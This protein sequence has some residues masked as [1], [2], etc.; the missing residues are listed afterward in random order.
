PVFSSH[1][2]A[3]RKAVLIVVPDMKEVMQMEVLYN[4]QSTDSAAL[5][6]GFWFT[7]NDVEA[8]D[9]EG[10]GFDGAIDL[11]MSPSAGVSEAVVEARPSKEKGAQLFKAAACAGCHS[12][13]RETDG[14]Y[15]PPFKDVFMSE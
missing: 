10:A 9:L 11:S 13:G 12:T 2:S 5:E 1:I 7:V 8:I 14:F 6:D 3:D 4:L 15:G